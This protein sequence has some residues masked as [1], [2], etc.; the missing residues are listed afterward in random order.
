MCSTSGADH[1]RRTHIQSSLVQGGKC[2]RARSVLSFS[3]LSEE[4]AE[5]GLWIGKQKIVANREVLQFKLS[6]RASVIPVQSEGNYAE[7]V[8]PENSVKRGDPR[9]T[10]QVE[11]NGLTGCAAVLMGKK[12][13]N[14]EKSKCA[15]SP[16]LKR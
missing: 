14:G 9:D 4:G 13:E 2:K 10:K 6:K 16:Q 1:F 12:R 7:R 5:T 11:K 8:R 15:G 3:E